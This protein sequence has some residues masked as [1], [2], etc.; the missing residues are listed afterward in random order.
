MRLRCFFISHLFVWKLSYLIFSLTYNML[1]SFFCVSIKILLTFF[2]KISDENLDCEEAVVQISSNRIS[3]YLKMTRKAPLKRF[4]NYISVHWC[5]YRNWDNN[6]R[7]F[8]I[9]LQLFYM[10]ARLL[11]KSAVYLTVW[12]MDLR[13]L[14]LNEN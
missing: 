1:D 10:V 11:K 2:G 6:K 8:F 13:F 4:L 14:A 7:S 3:W 9:A 5:W 12:G